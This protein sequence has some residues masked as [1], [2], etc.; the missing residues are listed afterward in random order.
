MKTPKGPYGIHAFDEWE[1]R[2]ALPP[3]DPRRQDLSDTRQSPAEVR[4]R[5]ATPVTSFAG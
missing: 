1:L 5:P 3:D 4:S 2:R